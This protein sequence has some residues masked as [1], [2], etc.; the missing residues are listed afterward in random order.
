VLSAKTEP[1]K[2]SN[3]SENKKA[4]NKSRRERQKKSFIIV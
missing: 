3:L 2:F 4:K 1:P